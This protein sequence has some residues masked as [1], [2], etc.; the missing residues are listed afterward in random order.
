VLDELGSYAG[1][2]LGAQ[3]ARRAERRAHRDD[4]RYLMSGGAFHPV[5]Q[6]V[7]DLS[8]GE[9][10]GYEALTRFASGRRPDLV[11]EEAHEAGLGVE[12]ETACALAAVR[13]AV[14]L[15]AG[16][17]LAVNFSPASVIAG[18]VASVVSE[19]D[20]PLVVEVTEHIEVLSYAAVRAAVER[21]PG[22]RISVDDA[23]A[24]Y[25][26][27]RHILELQP[28]FVKLDIGLVRNIDADP[29]RQALAAGLRHY[30]EQTG[31][32]LIA[33]GV[34]TT[35]ERDALV[36]LRIPLAQGFLYGRPAPVGDQP[37]LPGQDGMPR[38]DAR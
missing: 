16:G 35:A 38:I 4:I 28:E 1:Q 36:R 31:T 13:A 27:L 25:A 14:G 2:V 30:A 22:V 29:A 3:A 17:W 23:G 15:P 7:V 37:E 8:T 34:E 5:F 18:S 21:S 33:E 26:S 20:R 10:L 24:G 11:F 9:V 6:P 19:A 32:T 12:L